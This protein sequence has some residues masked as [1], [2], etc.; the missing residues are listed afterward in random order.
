MLEE[1]GSPFLASNVPAYLPQD[2]QLAQRRIIHIAGQY[3][4]VDPAKSRIIVYEADDLVHQQAMVHSIQFLPS[5]R[6]RGMTNH[7]APFR[8]LGTWDALSWVGRYLD[9]K[10]SR[11]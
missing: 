11:Q 9:G 2:P 4:V 3:A 5:R 6:A 8:F 1:A 7:E 10:D